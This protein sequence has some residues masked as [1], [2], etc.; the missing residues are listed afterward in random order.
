[1]FKLFSQLILGRLIPNK[2]VVM[3]KKFIMRL[4]DQS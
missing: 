2:E 1:M 3:N 4:N